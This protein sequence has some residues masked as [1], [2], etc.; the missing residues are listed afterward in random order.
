MTQ[1]I[2]KEHWTGILGLLLLSWGSWQALAVVPAETY[3]GHVFRIFFIHVPSA[4][5]S[6]LVGTFAFV[7]A[8]LALRRR[9]RLTDARLEASIEVT[10]LY[11]VMVLFQGSI[12]SLIHI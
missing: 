4:W 1:R 8:L 2:I 5:N 10:L 9:N 3:M 12:L 7:F 11:I 6:L